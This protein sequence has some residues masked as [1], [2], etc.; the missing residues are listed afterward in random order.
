MKVSE[1][2]E[3]ELEEIVQHAKRVYSNTE[4]Q[5]NQEGEEAKRRRA[6]IDEE[7][8]RAEIDEE[9]ERAESK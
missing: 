8:D 4:H 7:R 9:R 5:L 6:K 2:V 1:N 3:R